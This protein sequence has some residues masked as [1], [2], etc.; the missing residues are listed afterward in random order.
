MYKIY[1]IEKIREIRHK[2]KRDYTKIIIISLLQKI[3]K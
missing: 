3:F 2:D 1:T